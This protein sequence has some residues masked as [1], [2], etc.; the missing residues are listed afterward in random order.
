MKGRAAAVLVRIMGSRVVS[1]GVSP[2]VVELAATI[3]AR[4]SATT[5]SCLQEALL[6]AVPTL[7][8]ERHNAA[9]CRGTPKSSVSDARARGAS[10]ETLAS[11]ELVLLGQ[12]TSGTKCL[13]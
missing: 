12:R 9:Q 11:L 3:I 10:P 13:T 6:P 5:L 4:P 2:D 8:S 7:S 1:G